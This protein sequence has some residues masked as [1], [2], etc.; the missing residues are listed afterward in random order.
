M[1]LK[2]CQKVNQPEGFKSSV[3]VSFPVRG[4]FDV[5]Q[6]LI[7]KA[8]QAERLVGKLDGITQVLPNIDFFLRMYSL[9]D[10]S[11]SAQIEGTQATL[12]DAIELDA[13]IDGRETDASD[14]LFYIRAL[15]Y[16]IERVKT[17][18]LSLRFIRELHKELMKGA[19]ATHFS[20]PGEFRRSQNWIGGTS[21]SNASFVPPPVA[22]MHESLDDFE[23]FLYS[24]RLTLPIIHIAYAHAQFETIHPFLDGNG[25]TGRLLITF[26]L[27]K[28][29][30]LEKPVLFLSSFFK[31]HQKLYY[32][33]LH[34]YHEG[35][36]FGWLDFFLDGII[37]TAES[38]I[39]VSKN[40]RAL[41]D[42]DMMK[43]QSLAKRESESGVL[44]LSKLYETPIVTT[45]IIMAW[46]GFTRAGAQK[47]LDRFMSLDIL[48]TEGEEGVYDRK[49][50]YKQ[51]LDAFI[52]S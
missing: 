34:E 17:F 42:S 11:S 40:I 18:P 44:V 3:P 1:G 27:F 52:D 23:K 14:I 39:K 33:R 21:P 32:K 10:A 38:S 35:D 9:K 41:R 51:Y 19:R 49:Y 29:G 15:Q 28:K 37:A 16:G 47:L 48:V 12:S 31:Q 25:R 4:M 46:T 5:P 50:I 20:A 26:L 24:E 43:F 7:N 8:A 2:I 36:V 6:A 22:A 13:G 45:K 30:L